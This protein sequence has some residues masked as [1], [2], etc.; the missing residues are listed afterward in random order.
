[1]PS[2]A[3]LDAPEDLR[4][5]RRHRLAGLGFMA[6]LLVAF[7]FYRA[8]EPARRA[9]ARKAAQQENVRL[10]HELY[11]LHC[12]SCHG[13]DGRGGRSAPTLYAK[14]L[15]G[16]V[17]DEQLAWLIA[18]GIPGTDMPAYELDFGGPLTLQ[19][20]DQ[21]VAY[22]DRL[23]ETAPSVPDWRE[24]ARAPAPPP[25]FPEDEAASPG[26]PAVAAAEA[27]A[28]QVYAARCASCHGPEGR[29]TATAGPIR[30]PPAPYDDDLEALV[31]VISQGVRGTTMAAF[32]E[33]QGGPLGAETIRALARWLQAGGGPGGAPAEASAGSGAAP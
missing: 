13:E 12:A 8:G 25:L 23:E 22:L 15:L 6:L 29:G 5:L 10:G 19:D 2:P 11:G 28:P 7:P 9:E 3:P 16:S 1:M 31:Q 17:D 27:G 26:G 18:A 21:L 33:D 20:I 30:P 32:A 4:T 24:G 14:E